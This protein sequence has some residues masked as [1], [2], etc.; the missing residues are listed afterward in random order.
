M[1]ERWRLGWRDSEERALVASFRPCLVWPCWRKGGLSRAE[2]RCLRPP[3]SGSLRAWSRPDIP[4]SPTG[5]QERA[6]E[7]SLPAVW[8]GS[9]KARPDP[10]L[11]ERVLRCQR[12]R[13]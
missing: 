7:A 3:L 11:P 9:S 12:T 2:G 8:A 1:Q 13:P 5:N 10:G 6:Q 4:K